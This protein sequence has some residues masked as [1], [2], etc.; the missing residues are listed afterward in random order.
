LSG[1]QALYFSRVRKN[2]CAP[3]EDDRARA[4]RQQQVL[5]AMRDKVASPSN[6]PSTFFRAPFIAWQAPKAIRSD[7]HGPGLAALFLDL[8]TGGSGS[9]KV[10]LPDVAQPFI[11]G[12]VNVTP[13]ERAA[14]AK[15]L[16][17]N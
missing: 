12:A 17:G 7:M 4:K 15:Y 11:N 13:S 6:W 14:A 9:T 8:L 10:L 3:N 16:L 5:A 2:S 1:Q